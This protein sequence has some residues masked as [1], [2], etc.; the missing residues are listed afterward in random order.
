[1]PGR[2]SSTLASSNSQ[3]RR[4]SNQSDGQIV[5]D[6]AAIKVSASISTKTLIYGALPKTSLGKFKICAPRES[7]ESEAIKVSAAEDQ[8]SEVE[9]RTSPF[10]ATAKAPEVISKGG[11]TTDEARRRLAKSGPNAMPDTSA[12]PIRMALEKFWAPVPWMLEAAIVVELALGKYVEAAI[13]ALLLV[14]NA[15]LGLFQESRAQATLAAL[16]SRLALTAS[17]QRDGAWKTVPAAEVVPGDVVKLSL[18]AVVAADVKLTGGQV[19][20]DQSML[21]GESVPIEA[22]AGVQTYAGA[23]VRRGEAEAEVTATGTQT[24][25]GRTAELVRTA[26]VVSTQQKAVLAWCA[27]SP[28]STAASSFCW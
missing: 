1:L 3:L 18:G 10:T 25:F 20:L 15:A 27:I 12:H 28:P 24:K 7:R 11:L 13:I 14:F 9:G 2:R 16:K 8:S 17:V 23:L 5:G 19:L 6:P 21:T 4:Y 22:G 26:H